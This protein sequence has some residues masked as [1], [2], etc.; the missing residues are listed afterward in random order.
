MVHLLKV[1]LA[2]LLQA[3]LRNILKKITHVTKTLFIIQLPHRMRNTPSLI[4]M[5][6]MSDYLF[7]LYIKLKV[8]TLPVCQSLESVKKLRSDQGCA[9]AF[10]NELSSVLHSSVLHSSRAE[11][12]PAVGWA[13]QKEWLNFSYKKW[14]ILVKLSSYITLRYGYKFYISFDTPP[15]PRWMHISTQWPEKARCYEWCAWCRQRLTQWSSVLQRVCHG[16]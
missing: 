10:L 7:H 3:E 1:V 2:R 14:V 9:S 6:I 5:R 4:T 11:R 13:I 16:I 12:L 15:P 8:V